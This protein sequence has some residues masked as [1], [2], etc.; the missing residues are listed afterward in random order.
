MPEDAGVEGKKNSFQL[1]LSDPTEDLWLIQLRRLRAWQEDLILRG[2]IDALGSAGEYIRGLT[3]RSV[4]QGVAKSR[5]T[6][7]LTPALGQLFNEWQLLGSSP[8]D[9]W[10]MLSI[11]HDFPTPASQAKIIELFKHPQLLAE[12]KEVGAGVNL[13]YN[14][15]WALEK[16]FPA[17]SLGACHAAVIDAL[18]KADVDARTIEHARLF[19]DRQRETEKSREKRWVA[20]S[21]KLDR[22]RTP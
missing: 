5:M 22:Y 16:H 14:A 18:Q 20:K 15:L 8:H 9:V 7:T 10:T 12:G 19:L 13:R 21:A 4:H 11:A 3:L 1:L 6:E 17:D 2:T